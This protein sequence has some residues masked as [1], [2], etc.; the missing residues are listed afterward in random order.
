[1]STTTATTPSQS[2]YPQVNLEIW[3]HI[4]EKTLELFP[5]NFA[6]TRRAIPVHVFQDQVT[7]AIDDH[8]DPEKIL[9]IK[10]ILQGQN[11]IFLIAKPADMD[12]A[13]ERRY[14]AKILESR[15]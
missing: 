4:P 12:Q 3:P 13:L 5:I 1:M 9:A 6:R 14:S 10:S 15:S 11:V 2:K 8:E 7:V